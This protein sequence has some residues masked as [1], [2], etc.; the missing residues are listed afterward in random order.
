[1]QY[2]LPV[3]SIVYIIGKKDAVKPNAPIGTY[4]CDGSVIA[5]NNDPASIYYNMKLVNLINKGKV[6][7][8]TITLPNCNIITK[9]NFK[10]Y[11]VIVYNNYI[12]WRK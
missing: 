9:N 7:T 6:A 12:D 1:M 2:Q 5:V 8:E 3:G 4:H 10:L 11:P